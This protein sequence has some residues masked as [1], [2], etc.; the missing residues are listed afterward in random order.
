MSTTRTGKPARKPA[1][2]RVA[3][4]SK[5]VPSVR[6]KPLAPASTSKAQKAKTEAATKRSA[7]GASPAG[8]TRAAVAARKAT[9][10]ATTRYVDDAPIIVDDDDSAAKAGLSRQRTRRTTVRRQDQPSP[11]IKRTAV[12]RVDDPPP[13]TG[14]LLIERVT[15]AIERELSLIEVIVGGS[16]LKPQQRT[17]AERRARTLASLARTLGEVT[18]LR[19]SEEKVK[20][21]SGS[22]SL[23][24]SSD[25]AAAGVAYRKFVRAVAVAAVRRK[26]SHRRRHR[27]DRRAR[28]RSCRIVGTSQQRGLSHA[29]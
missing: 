1:A 16:H 24:F 18:R 11:R 15:R 3:S 29:Q 12:E 4:A 13:A 17:E 6:N 27:Q 25:R 10:A 9:I 7:A 23:L 20:P 14:A 26:H 8:K 21:V 22:Q 2:G 19:A 5:K 28:L